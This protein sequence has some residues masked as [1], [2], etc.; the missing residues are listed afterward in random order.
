L[1][2]ECE[3]TTTQCDWQAPKTPVTIQDLA[4]SPGQGLARDLR[5]K[6]EAGGS[7]PSTPTMESL[8]TLGLFR[9]RHS[10]N[11]FLDALWRRFAVELLRSH[12][13]LR[14]PVPDRF[15]TDDGAGN[16]AVVQTPRVPTCLILSLEWPVSEV[17]PDYI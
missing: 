17:C 15:W 13:V 5:C 14:I 16:R 7:S 8:G 2:A 4:I 6:E 11:N 1:D 3:L 10:D 12:I 9:F